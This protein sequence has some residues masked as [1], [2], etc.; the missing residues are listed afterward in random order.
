MMSDIVHRRSPVLSTVIWGL[1]LVWII[2]AGFPFLWTL[3]GS[4]KVQGDFFS[5]ADWTN[6]VYG[7]RTQIET[8]G[9]SHRQWVLRRLG[10]QRVLACRVEHQHRR[11]FCGD[12]LIDPWYAWRLRPCPLWQ[13]ICVLS[14]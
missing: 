12:H 4:F 3:W 2:A 1:V 14:V 5:K 9:A 6:A 7:V 13:E 11:G 8:G 10:H